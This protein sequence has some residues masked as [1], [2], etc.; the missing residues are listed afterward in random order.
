MRPTLYVSDLDGTLLGPQAGLS[1][2]ARGTLRE[3]LAQGLPFTVASAR[4]V[5]SIRPILGELPLKLPVIEFN[6]AFL[7]DLSGRH[8]VVNAI[9]PGVAAAVYEVIVRAG[10]V[11]VLSTFDGEEDHVYFSG[12]ANE[13]VRWYVEDRRAQRDPRWREVEHLP[14]ALRE[15]VV[16]FTVID[17]AAPLS[18][19][20]AALETRFGCELELR[21][22]EHLYA[23]GWHWLT[24]HDARARKDRAIGTLAGRYGLSDHELVVFG[25]Q[26][27]DIP[28]FRA[29]QRAY[30]VAN[31]SD[32]LKGHAT[33]VIAPN[34]EDGVVRFIE[35][36]WG[37]RRTPA[38]RS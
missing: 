30:A 18:D 10:R 36:E 20:Y 37:P 12:I 6:G 27:N 15:Q 32:E 17:R 8:E 7:S 9:D 33:A 23:R 19:L 25:D 28:M 34:I 26:S 21:L 16:C 35:A 13:G 2:Y 29:A 38:L 1:D 22:V 11:P 3:L 31:A 5:A 4:S 24:V 14:L